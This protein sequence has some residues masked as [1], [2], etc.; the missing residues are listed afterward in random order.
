MNEKSPR[1]KFMITNFFKYVWGA[2]FYP[3]ITFRHVLQE[4]KRLTYGFVGPLL[5]GISYAIGS[6]I[7]YRSGLLPYGWDP[8]IKIPLEKFF[9]WQ[10]FY[11][12][13][14]SIGTW[15]FFGGCV[16]L[17]SIKVDGKGTFEDNLALLGFSLAL[18]IPALFIPDIIVHHVLPKEVVRHPFFWTI[19]N[20]LRLS[21]GTLWVM[22]ISIIAVREAQQISFG[23]AIIVTIVSYIPTMA[24]TLTYIH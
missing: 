5:L 17:A 24:L 11:V 3:T 23:S 10:T 6:Y 1:N 2:I 12:I 9:Y 18:G 21:L 8:L 16:Q 14:V 15:I 4:E 13:P 20:P 19:V 22:I 7:A